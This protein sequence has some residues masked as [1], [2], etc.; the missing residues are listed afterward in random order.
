MRHRRHDTR[1]DTTHDTARHAWVD[2]RV[3]GLT[4][5]HL[6]AGAG[7]GVGAVVAVLEVD[8]GALGVGVGLVGLGGAL[9]S[10]LPSKNI[11]IFLFLL[12]SLAKKEKVR[13]SN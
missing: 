11:L 6:G 12:I 4:D 3:G 7:D 10:G 9:L 8:G 2:T 5:E 13:N 1:H